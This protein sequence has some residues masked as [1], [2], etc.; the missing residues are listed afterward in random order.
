MQPGM[1]EEGQEGGAGGVVCQLVVVLCQ[2]RLVCWQAWLCRG[3][4]EACHAYVTRQLSVLGRGLD[5][6]PSWLLVPALETI[7]SESK[8]SWMI[9]MWYSGQQLYRNANG[10]YSG[11]RYTAL[12]TAENRPSG[13]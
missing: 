8:R 11:A 3:V 13:A 10:F 2:K 4:P 6:T 7:V 12:V 9:F 5:A 1:S